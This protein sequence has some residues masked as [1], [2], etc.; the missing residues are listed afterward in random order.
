MNIKIRKKYCRFCGKEMVFN[1]EG[2]HYGFVDLHYCKECE[3]EEP[4]QHNEMELFNI[5]MEHY[6]RMSVSLQDLLIQQGKIL[7]AIE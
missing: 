4:D 5:G 7:K 6:E 2:K 1:D 3:N